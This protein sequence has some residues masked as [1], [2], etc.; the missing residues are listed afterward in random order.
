[1]SIELTKHETELEV[2]KLKSAAYDQIAEI[3]R[4][5]VEIRRCQNNLQ[6]INVELHSL[7]GQTDEQAIDFAGL[8]S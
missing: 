7:E 2:L 6:K 5:S 8:V 1:M 4:L 3:E